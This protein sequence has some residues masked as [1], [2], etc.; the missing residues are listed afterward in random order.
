MRI[1]TEHKP[2]QIYCDSIWSKTDNI[3][4]SDHLLHASVYYL[5]GILQSRQKLWFNEGPF[6]TRVRRYTPEVRAEAGGWLQVGGPLELLAKPEP[7]TA[8][9]RTICFQISELGKKP[10]FALSWENGYREP[11]CVSVCTSRIPRSTGTYAAEP[12]AT[13]SGQRQ[14]ESFLICSPAYYST[15]ISLLPLHSEKNPAQTFGFLRTKLITRT[16]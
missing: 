4:G 2:F 11:T 15:G 9:L 14:A 3:T 1:L 13:S 6:V 7:L 10:S 8:K 12:L 16:L 5:K